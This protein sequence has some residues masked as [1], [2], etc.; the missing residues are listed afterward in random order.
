MVLRPAA[1]LTC[2][3]A[4][5]LIVPPASA[6]SVPAAAPDA[7][8]SR[9]GGDV[10]LLRP[11]TGKF[12]HITGASQPKLIHLPPLPDF[13][14]DPFY[15]TYGSTAR[16]GACHRGHGPAGYYGAETSGCDSPLTLVNATFDWIRDNIRDDIDFIVWTGDTA[17]HD[18]D[19][20]HPRS[21]KQVRE[22][23]ELVV[24]KFREVFARDDD[25]NDDD[26]TNDFVIPIVPTIGNNDILPHNIFLEG[27]NRWTSAY[28]DIWR[29]FIPE[30]QRHQFQR[31]GWFQVEV[32]PNKLAIF[33]LNTMY[34]FDSNSAVDG[35]AIKSEPGYEHMEW[36]RVQLQIL[37]ER[38]MKAILIGHV[39]PARTENKQSWDE[40]CWQ[41]YA[42]WTRQYRDVIVTSL[43]GHMNIDHF[44]L[45]DFNDIRK[46]TEKGRMKGSLKQKISLNPDGDVSVVSASD[47]L[48][49]LRNEWA[50]LPSP[51]S[52]KSAKASFEVEGN[53]DSA[54]HPAQGFFGLMKKKRGRKENDKFLEEIG[55]PWGER[56]SFSLVGPSIVPN[57]FPTLRVFDYNITGLEAL[58]SA[59]F[60]QHRPEKYLKDVFENEVDEAEDEYEEDG[61]DLSSSKKSKDRE[62]ARKKHKK[63][64]KYKFTVPKPPS[65]SSPPGPAYSPQTLSLLGYTQYYA[66]LTRINNDFHQSAS[67]LAATTPG[68]P[69]SNTTTKN[70][71]SLLYADYTDGD[72]AD[73]GDGFAAQRWREGKHSGK[74]PKHLTP[75]PLPFEFEVYY[76]THN[77][78]DPYRLEGLT[79]RSYI[80]L[81][82]RI[83]SFNEKADQDGKK[84]KKHKKKHHKKGKKQGVEEQDAPVKGANEWEDGVDVLNGLVGDNRDEA[85]RALAEREE[86]DYDDDDD[87]EIYETDDGEE[88]DAEKKKKKKKKKKKHHKKGPKHHVW[89]TFI[90]RAFVG[91]MDRDE[92]EEQFGWVPVPVPGMEREGREEAA[93]EG[94]GDGEL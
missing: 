55:G 39:P 46:S 79:V 77:E 51:K 50:N 16:D 64:K 52:K 91:T 93:H 11:L 2:A 92:I 45:Q 15:K 20:K 81:A 88:V 23:N 13:H 56:F 86:S 24:A 63:K 66:N 67:Y 54:V 22:L 33:S 3:L 70:P 62:S 30:E 47:Y 10:Q 72:D 37:R 94:L 59:E 9:N 41:K 53:E 26:P 18:N 90:E 87:N 42:L 71:T 60:P 36:L 35:C 6:L 68:S 44:Q 76:S 40:T 34:F 29:S 32:I 78:S 1:S 65:K 4:S 17:R 31:G 82:R 61:D 80:N 83:G 75:H 58:G 19:E 84:G 14:P 25:D 73:F 5:T 43:Y 85:E 27:P 7:S 12:L 74:K 69:E 38:G 8:R 21:D 48:M 28:L 57:Y 49:D 89:Y